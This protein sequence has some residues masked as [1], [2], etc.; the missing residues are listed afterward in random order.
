MV[1]FYCDLTYHDNFFDN[2]LIFYF[3]EKINTLF[4]RYNCFFD[5]QKIFNVTFY[6]IFDNCYTVFSD[7][8]LR[9]CIVDKFLFFASTSILIK[10]K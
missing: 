10:N 5:V 6:V 4:C 1:Y 7:S 3:Y 2:F 9:L 8:S